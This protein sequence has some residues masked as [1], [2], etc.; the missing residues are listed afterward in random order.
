[1]LTLIVLAAT[2]PAAAYKF[3]DD[4]T[5]AVQGPYRW[6]LPAFTAAVNTASFTTTGPYQDPIERGILAWDQTN[7][8]GSRL[9][10]SVTT[11]YQ[12]K[13]RTHDQINSVSAIVMMELSGPILDTS[14]FPCVTLGLTDVRY[15][16]D[17]FGIGSNH[18]KEA[19]ILVDAD[20]FW[21]T[22]E[23]GEYYD[24]LDQRF[25][26]D[27]FDIE[28]VV[29]HEA[30][31]AV[32]LEHELGISEEDEFDILIDYEGWPATMQPALSGGSAFDDGFLLRRYVAN[33]DDR[34]GIRDLYIPLASAPVD[35]A[36]QSY[37]VD[38]DEVLLAVLGDACGRWLGK[39][40]ARPNPKIDVLAVA[41]ELGEA[42][43]DCPE[44]WTVPPV[45]PP[46]PIA[47][48]NGV[49]LGVQFTLN[50]LGAGGG[51]VEWQVHFTNDLSDTDCSSP[52]CWV[53]YEDTST[54]TANT[55]FEHDPVVIVVPLDAPVGDYYVQLVMDTDNAWPAEYDEGNNT[56]VWNQQVHALG[57]APCGCR[58]AGPSAPTAM[59]ALLGLIAAARR[60]RVG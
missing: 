6:E 33:E 8:P 53:L 42:Y 9:A 45:A 49:F 24:T 47:L 18:I 13:L 56:A 26:D 40:T 57:Q 36:A 3:H 15:S 43:G 28:Q 23:P 25:F 32:G 41:Q 17:L 35:W 12:T 59:V 48:Y 27:E 54:I 29:L 46:E 22:P 39:G 10:T 21:R 19:D 5:G 44:T 60:R 58:T 34:E 2:T 20:C 7:V 37:Q 55:P 16:N 50:N 31:H 14:L 38:D 52:G 11:T 51:D 1:M 30:G 4:P